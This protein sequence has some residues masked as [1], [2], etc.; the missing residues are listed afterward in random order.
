MKSN[1]FTLLSLFMISSSLMANP[2]NKN[3]E[4]THRNVAYGPHERNVLDFWQAPGEGPRPLYF[5]IHGGGWINGDKSRVFRVQDYLDKGISVVSI[6]YRR[7]RTD[8]LPAPVYDAARA[9][10]FVRSK[11]KEWN[12]DKSKVLLAG[13]S[14]GACSA[15]WIACH[16]DLAKPESSDPIERES[17]RISGIVV[18]GGQTSIDP[19][20]AGPW[21]GPKVYH[22]MIIQAVGEKDI[23]AVFKNYAKHAKLFKEFSP[24]NHLSKD[25]PPLYLSYG[26]HMEVPAESFG[27]GIH[28]G[29]FGVKMKEKSQ[30]V[31]HDKV[32]LDIAKHQKNKFYADQKAFIYAILLGEK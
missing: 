25:D 15:M 19:K 30:K 13:N 14:A 11:A 8:I 29:M 17:T 6:N 4:A 2:A 12:I 32:F 24:I 5:F 22:G 7:T 21:I 1:L 10:Q 27:S 16:D 23:D 9:L 20:Q 28:H 31:G 18:A 3:S 26:N